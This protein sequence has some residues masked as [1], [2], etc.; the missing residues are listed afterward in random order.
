LPS[1]PRSKRLTL[2]TQ[3]KAWTYAS[4]EPSAPT[5][6][7]TLSWH[8]SLLRTSGHAYRK[9]GKS[10][11][12]I[13]GDFE[14]VKRDYREYSDVPYRIQVQSPHYGRS[15]TYQWAWKTNPV[16]GDWPANPASS[17]ATLAVAGT[18]M[19][20]AVIPTN[21]LSGL[22]VALG[23]LK[24]D[25]I[26]SLI[27][28]NTWENRTKLARGAGSEYLNYQFGWLPLV[29]D[30]RKFNRAVTDRDKILRQYERNSGK[31]VR[32]RLEETQTVEITTSVNTLE[33]PTPIL[34]SYL[35]KNA[36]G[37][38]TTTTITKRRRWLAACFTY[39]LAPQSGSFSKRNEQ[40]ANKLYGTRV[41]P[42]TVWE[43]APWSWATDWVFNTG[44]VLH[45]VSAFANDGLVMPYAYIME[46]AS[47]EKHIKL[48]GVSYK[49]VYAPGGF[50]PPTTMGQVFTTT[51]KKRIRAT[52]FGFGLNPLLFTGRQLSIL[53][54]LGLSRS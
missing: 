23:E 32:R 1:L 5:T 3:S 41:T 15:G 8:H 26:P 12:D 44:D 45:N 34:P 42:S 47:V 27:G 53:A 2:Q 51:S 28:I 33:S 54:A 37:T 43:L 48:E 7:R 35:Y 22:T 24:R 39:Y 46:E 52:P 40:L 21:P 19:I 36:L 18:R 17:D 20:K 38:L 6:T 31:R 10:S 16:V 25:G 9:L 14:V 50:T 4:G 30:I 11:A 49:S 29:S 13:G